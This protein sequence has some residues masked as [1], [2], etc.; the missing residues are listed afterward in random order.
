MNQTAE[1][2]SDLV[3]K[4]PKE[5]Q[6]LLND[7]RTTDEAREAVA[8]LTSLPAARPNGGVRSGAGF[9]AENPTN[10]AGDGRL[11]I[12]NEHQEFTYVPP[13]HKGTAS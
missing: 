5:L 7:A 2:A 3:S 8:S 6:E 10:K 11:Q 9:K 13:H 1:R 12:V 4:P